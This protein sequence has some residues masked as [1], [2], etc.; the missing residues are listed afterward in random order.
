MKS[1]STVYKVCVC[2][3]SVPNA[4]CQCSRRIRLRFLQTSWMAYTEKDQPPTINT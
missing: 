1:L 3:E 2:K 4:M